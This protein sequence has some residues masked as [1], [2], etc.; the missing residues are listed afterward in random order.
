V[1]V[2]GKKGSIPNAITPDGIIYGCDHDAD[3]FTSMVGFGRIGLDTYI[4]LH[5]GRGS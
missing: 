2:P 4:T 5:A 3:Y 1:L